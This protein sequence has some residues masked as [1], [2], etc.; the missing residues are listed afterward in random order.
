MIIEAMDRRTTCQTKHSN[1]LLRVILSNKIGCSSRIIKGV[2]EVNCVIIIGERY[3]SF[4][5]MQGI[6]ARCSGWL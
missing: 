1:N 6:V 2:G 4:A 3:L 5:H